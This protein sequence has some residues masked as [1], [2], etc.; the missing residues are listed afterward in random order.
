M[1]SYNGGGYGGG[2]YPGLGQTMMFPWQMQGG[3]QPPNGFGFPGPQQTTFS[4][5]SSAFDAAG[6]VSGVGRAL[7]GG[8][9]NVGKWAEKNPQ[10]AS[11]IA[12]TAL[13]AYGAYKMGQAN[14]RAQALNEQ[15]LS[16]EEKAFQ[17]QQEQDAKEQERRKRAYAEI[18]AMREKTGG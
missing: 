15:R 11:D 12:G 4:A 6:T 10:L 5:P 17:Y 14:D 9:K 2:G 7:W 3:V 8:V 18:L 16:D 13:G 1:N